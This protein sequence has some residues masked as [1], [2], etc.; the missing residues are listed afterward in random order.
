MKK[1]MFAA[2]AALA[3]T[4][5]AEENGIASENIVGYETIN[6]VKANYVAFAVQFETTTQKELPIK[7]LFTINGEFAKSAKITGTC[8]Q[9]WVWDSAAGDWEKYFYQGGRGSVNE[10]WT[11]NGETDL[12]D[13]TVTVKAGQ[14]VFFKRG[15]ADTTLTCA[16]GVKPFT[17]EVSSLCVKATYT[18]LAYPWPTS[19]KV[20]DFTQFYADGA[21][22]AMSAKITGTCD[23]IWLWDSATGDWVKYYYQGGRGSVNEGWTKN[24]ETD[25]TEDPIPAG[26]GFFF[27]RQGAD[28][29]ITF[30]YPTEK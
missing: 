26:Q 14:T 12:I 7:N 23:Q 11:K 18:F 3:C 16:G 9:I 29:T 24:G 5:F 13:D 1:L 25:L 4:A 19:I 17:G 10:G 22:P 15:G 6:V 21:T 28:C 27:L 2:V 30:T 20:S 8:D